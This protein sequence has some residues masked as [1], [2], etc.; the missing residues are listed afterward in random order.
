MFVPVALHDSRSV[1]T[2][3][4]RMT[5]WSPMAERSE[6]S[7]VTSSG[8]SVRVRPYSNWGSNEKVVVR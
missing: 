5:D 8:S 1:G 3:V 6:S 7:K 4:E 2:K